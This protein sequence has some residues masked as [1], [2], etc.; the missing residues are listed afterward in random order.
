MDLFAPKPQARPSIQKKIER[1][2]AFLRKNHLLLSTG[3]LVGNEKPR[4]VRMSFKVEN[5]VN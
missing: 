4:D 2:Q 1:L 5:G 3:R